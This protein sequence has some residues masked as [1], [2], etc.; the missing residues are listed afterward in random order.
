MSR[1]AAAGWRKND[2]SGQHPLRQG[3]ACA[4]VVRGAYVSISDAGHV[5]SNSKSGSKSGSDSGSQW[6]SKS[7][8]QEER[9]G[10]G[11]WEK[12][13]EEDEEKRKEKQRLKDLEE[14]D[15]F[16]ER[17]KERDREKTKRIV[18]DRSSKA[19]GAAAADAAERRRLAEDRDARERA[20]PS[21]REHSRQEYLSKREL[22][23]IELLR[24]EIATEIVDIL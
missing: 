7:G 6:R 9:D 19:G 16:A 24:R 12:E 1:C 21:L 5:C 13:E 17:M 23:R 22:Q 4:G 18:E 11:G 3:G 8:S 2:G 20:M 14:R 10:V 15:A